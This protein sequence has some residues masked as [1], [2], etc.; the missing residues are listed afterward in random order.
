MFKCLG[1]DP[2][3]VAVVAGMIVE[4]FDVI[5]DIGA[6]QITGFIDALLDPFLFQTAEACA[7]QIADSLELREPERDDNQRI[8]RVYFIDALRRDFGE[9]TKAQVDG[10]VDWARYA[11][12]FAYDKDSDEPFLES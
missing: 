3:K 7:A 5:E 10:A 11:E 1:T 8:D 6:S 12:L 4:R 2:A 9:E